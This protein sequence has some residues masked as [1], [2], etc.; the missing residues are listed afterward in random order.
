MNILRGDRGAEHGA[1]PESG[2]RFR[3]ECRSDWNVACVSAGTPP[4][5]GFDDHC[6][7]FNKSGDWGRTIWILA[8]RWK[9]TGV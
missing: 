4:A 7:P 8:R 1:P 9:V 3:D 2:Q 5:L 6:S